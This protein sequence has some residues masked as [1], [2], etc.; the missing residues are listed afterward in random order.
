VIVVNITRLDSPIQARL[1]EALY[2]AFA[3]YVTRPEKVEIATEHTLIGAA[4]EWYDDKQRSYRADF[5][6]KLTRPGR[7]FEQ[8]R[9]LVE[10]DGAAFHDAERDA[11]RDAKLLAQ[12]WPTIRFTGREIY[13]DAAACARAAMAKLVALEASDATRDFAPASPEDSMAMAK[14][15]IEK[16]RSEK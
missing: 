5:S 1:A 10:A 3:P 11:R 15:F 14:A 13:R 7:T 8:A 9:L 12:G 4:A 6:I 2:V 16:L